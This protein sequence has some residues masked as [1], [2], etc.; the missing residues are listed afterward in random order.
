MSASEQ[1]R[2]IV[3]GVDAT[4]SADNAICVAI[5]LAHRFDASI[6]MVHAV[7]PAHHLGRE[8][9]PAD[10][11]AAQQAV[12]TRLGASLPGALLPYVSEEHHLVVEAGHPTQVL[13]E[14]AAV[15]GT[16]LLILGAHRRH[17]LLDLRSTAHAVLGHAECPVWIHAGPVPEV[18]RILV[19]VDLS[20]E[21]L[22]ALDAARA[23]AGGWGATIVALHCFLSPE[24]FYGHG[25]P[26]PGP[27]YVVDKLRDDARK[28]F[29][30]RMKAV[31]WG[32]VPHET[33]FLEASPAEQILKMQ[34]DVDLVMMGTH[35]RTGLS[36]V[37]L[38]SVARTIIGEA[39]VPVITMRAPEREWLI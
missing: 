2:R 32:D 4:G 14:R 3:V 9:G 28:E 26:V 37:I 5:D 20:D 23:W 21:S 8:T 19:P 38:G 27:T 33:V 11:G 13:L 29:E 31:S 39:Q 17:G 18:R 15:E 7:E 35:G 22:R 25:Y 6:E 1:P 30:Q 12:R 16:G 36:R 34:D 10:L 24:L